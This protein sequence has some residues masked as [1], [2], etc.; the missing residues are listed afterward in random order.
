MQMTDQEE[1]LLD[2]IVAITSTSCPNPDFSGQFTPIP[3]EG[4]SLAIEL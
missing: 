2:G 1:N 3:S 4:H